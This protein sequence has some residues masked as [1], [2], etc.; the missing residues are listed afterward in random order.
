MAICDVTGLA[1]GRSGISTCEPFRLGGREATVRYM[2]RGERLR[3]SSM[4]ASLFSALPRHTDGP[5][6]RAPTWQPCVRQGWA[7]ATLHHG[8]HLTL[9][10]PET[11]P[12]VPCRCAQRSQSVS[13]LQDELGNTFTSKFGPSARV[14]V[15]S[16]RS[17]G[18]YHPW[19]VVSRR[20]N[21]GN[22][23]YSRLCGTL[24]PQVIRVI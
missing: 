2:C 5:T 22:R 7:R 15:F 3:W 14:G 9:S 13:W 1:G 20:L 6:N 23:R 17:T 18:L 24:E 4:L 10:R 16:T 8:H 11:H 21:L 19:L 12:G